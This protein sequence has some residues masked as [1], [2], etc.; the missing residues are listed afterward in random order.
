LK[1][2]NFKKKVQKIVANIWKKIK[3]EKDF[4]NMKKKHSRKK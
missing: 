2:K 4:S 3:T 1:I